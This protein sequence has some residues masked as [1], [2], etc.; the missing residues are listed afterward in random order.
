MK[1]QIIISLSLFALVGCSSGGVNSNLSF[2]SPS[3][4]IKQYSIQQQKMD[5]KNAWDELDGKKV[6]IQ[7]SIKNNS[8]SIKKAKKVDISNIAKS[9][10]EKSDTIP[11]WF[12]SPPKSEDY[13][14]GAGEGRNSNE[15]KNSAL[16]YIASEIQT[17]ISSKYSK[18]NYYS[19]N[20]SST[21]F[22][23][24][25]KTKINAVVSKI[26]F[27]NIEIV[28]TV[29]VNNEI[30]LLLRINKKELFKNLKTKFEILNSKLNSDIKTSEQYS[31]LDQLITLNKSTSK[32]ADALNLATILSTL[33]P[34]FNIKP[35]IQKYNSYIEKKNKIYHNLTFKILDNNPFSQKLIE[36]MNE[37]SYKIGNN[38]NIK[39]RVIPNIRYSTPYGISVIKA[40][41]QIKVIAKNEILKS[42]SI[43][44]KGIANT[45]SQAIIKAAVNFKEKVLEKGINK[46]LGFE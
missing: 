37:N 29:K 6:T 33:N 40:T 7:Q 14:Y 13:F 18:T 8:N 39:I 4:H 3:G 26:S 17:T 28:K 20:D 42:T 5:A 45:K 31:L 36:V 44:V 46:V 10:L 34:N 41:I 25:A 24:S 35:Y 2:S 16:N 38:S 21:N 9:M 11:D 30:Y 27:S 15:A 12:Y 32:I 19:K 43:E 1:K 23:Q 22:Y